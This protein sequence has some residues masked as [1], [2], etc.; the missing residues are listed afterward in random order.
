VCTTRGQRGSQRPPRV[1]A[2]NPEEPNKH[3]T[4]PCPP[5]A[6]ITVPPCLPFSPTSLPPNRASRLLFAS[7]LPSFLPAR[8]RSH[9]AKPN[10]PRRSVRSPPAPEANGRSPDEVLRRR[11]HGRRARRVRRR[12]HRGASA[13]AGLRRSGRGA[14]R[15]GVA[16]RCGLRLPLLLDRSAPVCRVGSVGCESS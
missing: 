16:R 14:S 11:R 1:P 3:V 7:C 4:F 13:R 12:R 10:S 9:A 2:S 8:D 5:P 6:Y 15:C